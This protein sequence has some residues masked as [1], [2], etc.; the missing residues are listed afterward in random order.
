VPEYVNVEICQTTLLEISLWHGLAML[1]ASRQEAYGSASAK[2]ETS[3][4]TETSQ[5]NAG[6][7]NLVHIPGFL[8][9]GGGAP[10]GHLDEALRRCR[11]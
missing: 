5:K 8:L 10:D 2:H 11:H 9:Q 7:A 1:G 3:K 4:M 6:V